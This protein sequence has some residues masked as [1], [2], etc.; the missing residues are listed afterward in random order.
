MVMVLLAPVAAGVLR[1]RRHDGADSVAAPP[2]H[3]ERGTQKLTAA[4]Q[5][6]DPPDAI[7]HTEYTSTLRFLDVLEDVDDLQKKIIGDFGEPY[8][9]PIAIG[10]IRAD[11]GSG[12]VLS[13]VTS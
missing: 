4:V 5:S 10:D 7:T 2:H 13:P 9:A 8:R 1:S 6:G 12:R 3:L 11:V